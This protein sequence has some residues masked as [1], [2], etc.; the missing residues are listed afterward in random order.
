ME[1]AA[2]RTADC[3]TADPSDNL[4]NCG[5]VRIQ[6]C[7]PGA[8]YCDPLVTC[9]QGEAVGSYTCGPCPSGTFTGSGYENQGGCIDVDEC[10][11]GTDNCDP[12]QFCNNTRGGFNC[13]A[14]DAGWTM[15]GPL[16]CTDINECLEPSACDPLT[17]CTNTPGSYTCSPC[18][19]GYD[20]DPKS[21]AG[22]QSCG[23][24][25]PVNGGSSVGLSSLLAVWFIFCLFWQ[26]R[27]YKFDN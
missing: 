13:G 12:H 6:Y 3:L 25:C 21:A 17:T 10:T 16:N 11:A 1:Y 14:C 2:D 19:A 27:S 9:N 26:L 18:P 8:Q 4:D 22:C 5:C 20:G 15:G 24:H 7:A 23:T